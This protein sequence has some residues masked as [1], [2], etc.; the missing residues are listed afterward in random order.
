MW[1]LQDICRPLTQDPDHFILNTL[2]IVEVD[3]PTEGPVEH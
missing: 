3:V 1:A 2:G